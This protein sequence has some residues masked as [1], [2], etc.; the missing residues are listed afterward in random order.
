MKS[1]RNYGRVPIIWHVPGPNSESLAIYL[2]EVVAGQKLCQEVERVTDLMPRP[3]AFVKKMNLNSR[4]R[5]LGLEY[6][7]L[8]SD[9]DLLEEESKNLLAKFKIR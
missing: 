9:A 1:E 6:D 4:I 2:G 3:Y 8:D 7:Q 5:L